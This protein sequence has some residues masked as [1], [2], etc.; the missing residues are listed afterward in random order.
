MSKNIKHVDRGARSPKRERVILHPAPFLCG[1]IETEGGIPFF[2]SMFPFH[3]K[4]SSI[5][6][7]GFLSSPWT[8]DEIDL[9][10]P[11][12]IVPY[13]S[14]KQVMSSECLPHMSII[15]PCLWSWVC[16]C[17]K[18]CPLLLL[19]ANWRPVWPRL[20]QVY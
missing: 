4:C 7:F 20:P 3:V 6:W 9:L 16:I 13:F 19:Q 18:S 1:G 17:L 15:Y 12:C 10:P 5:H 11:S 14:L 8:F 2:G